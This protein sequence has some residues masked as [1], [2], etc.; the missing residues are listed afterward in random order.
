M[1]QAILFLPLVGAIF[2]GALGPF[3]GPRPAEVIATT[4]VLMSE[5]KVAAVGPTADIMQRLDLYPLTGRAEAGAV[6]A[7][8][9]ERHEILLERLDPERVVHAKVALAS[10]RISGVDPEFLATSKESRARPRE[11]RLG[12]AEI[13]EHRA[14]SRAL[15]GKRVVRALPGGGFL[16]VTTRACLSAHVHRHRRRTCARRRCLT[17]PTAREQ[18]ECCQADAVHRAHDFGS[19]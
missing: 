17:P 2:A 16:G 9:V 13:A 18:H 11:R 12:V 6:V 3:T 19:T 7:A 8:T 10:L 14:R 15:H 5:G 1:Y 4:L